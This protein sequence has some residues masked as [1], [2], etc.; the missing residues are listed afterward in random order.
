M[1]VMENK[2]KLVRLFSGKEMLVISL[3][4]RLDNEGIDSVVHND[5][6]D[7]FLLGVPTAIDLYINVSDT[8][9]AETVLR[10]FLLDNNT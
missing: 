1:F 5:S 2:N 9:K 8:E 6:Y 10:K 7:K 4:D 3:K